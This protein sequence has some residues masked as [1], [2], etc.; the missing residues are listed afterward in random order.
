MTPRVRTVAVG[1]P[2]TVPGPR[3]GESTS[4]AIWKEPV[5]GPVAVGAENLAGDEQADRVNHGGPEKS[6]Y[7]YAEEDLAWWRAEL[8]ALDDQVFGQNLT[9]VG[10]D[11]RD[12]RV[13]ERWRIGTA[14]LEVVQPRIPC[15]KLGLRA[16]DRAMPR[17]FVAA[18][19][20][21]VYLRVITPGTL[22]AGD[23]ITVLDRPEDGVPVAEVF[24]IFHHDRA[25]AARLLDAPGL[26]SWY[27][28]WAR[29]RLV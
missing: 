22:A 15:F 17:R 28:E 19:R 11:L 25:R 8:G 26:P 24:A 1:R 9:T 4:T 3:D 29:K 18:V 12:A 6:V 7:A 13:G 20:P 23:T 2:R 5:E 16:G 10:Y 21:G 14:L 27:H